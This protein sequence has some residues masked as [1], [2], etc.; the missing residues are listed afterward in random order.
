M[1][2][3]R[4]S[5]RSASRVHHAFVSKVEDAI[6]AAIEERAQEFDA[7][8]NERVSM[9]LRR[10]SKG[11]STELCLIKAMCIVDQPPVE[12]FA[13][14]DATFFHEETTH[15]SPGIVVEVKSRWWPKNL[16]SLA[17]A[18]TIGSMG[19]INC[20]IGFD[21]STG[22]GKLATVSIWRPDLDETGTLTCSN[23]ADA[24]M[25]RDAT[26][27][28][29]IGGSLE[30]LLEDLLVDDARD[31]IDPCDIRKPISLD[32]HFLA[33]LL[34]ES[35]GKPVDARSQK[36]KDMYPGE[37][38]KRKHWKYLSDIWRRAK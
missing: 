12:T 16:A 26:G 37:Y 5:P 22:Q 6:A 2:F 23:N 15:D 21:I 14:P 1:T 38:D 28:D 24:V 27:D 33:K 7:R 10:T 8:K 29:Q 18:Y 17:E 19:R 35:E 36:Q 4:E 25:F 32:F 9:T 34:D 13:T 31:R 30:I 20:V 3:L 11:G